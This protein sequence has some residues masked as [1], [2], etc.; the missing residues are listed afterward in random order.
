MW[1]LEPHF[2]F[3][4]DTLKDFLEDEM[5][6]YVCHGFRIKDEAGTLFGSVESLGF[7]SR[8][9]TLYFPP[10]SDRDPVNLDSGAM[11]RI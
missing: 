1:T 10:K 9:Y 7:D 2:A 8:Q 5:R 11:E 3:V 6:A 4:K